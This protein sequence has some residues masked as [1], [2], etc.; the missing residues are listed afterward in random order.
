MRAFLQTFEALLALALA[1]TLVFVLPFRLLAR[2]LKRGAGATPVPAHLAAARGLA[3]RIVHL[4]PRFPGRT[5]CLV[6]AL[7]GW[8]MLRRR[9]IPAVVRFGVRLDDG[10]L[11]AHAWLL[12]N[13]VAVLGGAEAGGF[14]PIGD[15]GRGKE[16]APRAWSD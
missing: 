16:T 4:A 11:A 8:L 9:G 2:L 7:A 1:W 5:T 15:F 6:R 13:G 10:K 12:V 3:R 14:T